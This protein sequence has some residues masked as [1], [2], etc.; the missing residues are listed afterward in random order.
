MISQSDFSR[1]LY[2]CAAL[3]VSHLVCSAFVMYMDLSGRWSQYSLH[4]KRV[5]GFRDYVNGWKSFC[6]DQL[7]LFLPF[8]TCCFMRSSK[9]IEECNDPW[10]ISLAKLFAGYTLGKLW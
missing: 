7:V 4:K 1:A 2:S 9:A 8:M 6:A 5:A 3:I 10:H